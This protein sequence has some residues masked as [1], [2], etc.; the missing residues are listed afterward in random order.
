MCVYSC[1][2]GAA[3]SILACKWRVRQINWENF[4]SNHSILSWKSVIVK[5]SVARNGKV[6]I[7]N[8]GDSNVSKTPF[9]SLY[10]FV[11]FPAA[12]F[13]GR[14]N[15]TFS[16][17]LRIGAFPVIVHFIWARFH[18]LSIHRPST[19]ITPSWIPTP[20]S[21]GCGRCGSGVTEVNSLRSPKYKGKLDVDSIV[22]SCSHI[23]FSSYSISTLM[24]Q[25]VCCVCATRFSSFK[26]CIDHPSHYRCDTSPEKR[27]HAP[28]GLN[29]MSSV[30]CIRKSHNRMNTNRY[31]H[32]QHIIRIEKRST[33]TSTRNADGRYLCQ[34]PNTIRLH[35]PKDSL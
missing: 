11:F 6:D 13:L 24:A 14:N 30:Q 32:D 18:A 17:E 3:F 19:P 23:V 8:G 26:F 4:G 22:V 34:H 2:S 16:G 7:C 9:F 1:D 12:P 15:E 28:D 29:S 33:R 35:V 20:Q 31:Q 21:R 27:M 10:V 25:R 5:R